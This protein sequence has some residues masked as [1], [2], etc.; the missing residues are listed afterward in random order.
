MFR[1][2]SA[3]ISPANILVYAMP[4]RFDCWRFSDSNNCWEFVRQYLIEKAKIPSEDVP[5]LGVCI[6][7]HRAKT[8]SYAEISKTFTQIPEPKDF[9]IACDFRGKL[10]VHVGIVEGCTIRHATQK[11]SHRDKISKFESMSAGQTRY[12]LHRSL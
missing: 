3:D 4:D 6:N 2:P 10:L 11:G 1:S 12:Y 5:K 8:S 7:D 9:A